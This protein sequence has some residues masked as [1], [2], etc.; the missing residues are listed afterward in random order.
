[1]LMP[2]LIVFIS[3]TVAV[4]GVPPSNAAEIA[5]AQQTNDERGIKVTVTRQASAN[6]AKTLNFEVTLETHAHDLNDDLTKSSMLITDGKAYLP[7][8][9]K[10]SPPGGH[11]RKGVLSFDAISPKPEAME[12]QI[13][14]SGDASPRSF[15]WQAK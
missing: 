12:L 10:G 7:L 8:A 4:L 11:H 5:Q 6:D 14:L 13:R 3:A 1:M 9:W 2:R 15:R